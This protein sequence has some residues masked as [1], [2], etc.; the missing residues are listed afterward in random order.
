MELAREGKRQGWW[1]SLGLAHTAYVGL[2]QDATSLTIFQSAVVPGL[3]QIADYIRAVHQVGIPR[4]DEQ[5]IEERVEERSK[6]QQILTGESPPSVEVLLDESVLHRPM[7]GPLVMHKQLDH[8]IQIA[9]QPNM[10]IQVVPYAVGAHPALESNFTILE[11]SGLAPTLVHAEGLAG[12]LYLERPLEVQRYL[13]VLEVLR[14]LALSPEDT[15]DF[16][17]HIRDTYAA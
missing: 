4:F 11:F 16:I 7:G 5:A 14:D 17:I 3:L 10:T 9:R 8:L 2:E 13:R 1:Q 15:V 6:R 12:Q